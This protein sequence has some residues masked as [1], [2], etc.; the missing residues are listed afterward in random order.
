MTLSR[1][2]VVLS[3]AVAAVAAACG[4]DPTGSASDFA[5]TYNLTSVNGASM[6][7]TYATGVF[8]GRLEVVGGRIVV[9]SRGRLLYIIDHRSVDGGGQVGPTESDTTV[10][11]FETRGDRVML[12][13]PRPFQPDSYVDTATVD[14]RTRTLT[15]RARELL[16]NYRSG[17]TLFYT[18]Q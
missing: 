11:A 10:I 1:R 16:P 18:K 12:K 5:G 6:P 2:F 14:S 17:Y 3:L 15:L 7:F 9:R 13:H 4:D 8:G